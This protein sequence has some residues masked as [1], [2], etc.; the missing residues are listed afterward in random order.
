MNQPRKE[1]FSHV[2]QEAPFALVSTVSRGHYHSLVSLGE[3]L[4]NS[5]Y[6]IYKEEE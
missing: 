4:E 6:H 5:G 1:L 2:L 3:A